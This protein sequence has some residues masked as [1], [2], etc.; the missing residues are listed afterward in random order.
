MKQAG[1]IIA[2]LGLWE[3]ADVLALFVPDFGAVPIYVWNHIGVGVIWIV[4]GAWAALSGD[5]RVT[6]RLTVITL[7][8][9]LWLIA[10]ALILRLPAVTAGLW[11]DLIVGASVVLLSGWALWTGSR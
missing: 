9:G 3:A 4:V 2:L 10:S 7:V 11:N 5:A 8:A 1:W 6:R